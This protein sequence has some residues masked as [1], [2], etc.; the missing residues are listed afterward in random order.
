MRSLF[1]RA[2]QPSRFLMARETARSL[3]VLR[4]VADVRAF[5]AKCRA[6]GKTVGFVPTMG[7]LH[8][9]HIQLMNFAKEARCDAVVASIFVNPKQFAP[10][11]DFSSCKERARAL[12]YHSRLLPSLPLQHAL[13]A[14]FGIL[15][16]VLT[17]SFF[18]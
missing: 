6:E 10:T 5:R 17:C 12:N 11:D 8:S 14:H 3:H 18:A 1:A 15:N 13:P 2:P 9:G 4:T 16:H 7:A